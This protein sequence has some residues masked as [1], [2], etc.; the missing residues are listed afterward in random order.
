MDGAKEEAIF[1]SELIERLSFSIFLSVLTSFRVTRL[2]S[3]SNIVYDN[4]NVEMPV[5]TTF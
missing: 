2:Q 4:R 5:H 3:E 1:Y